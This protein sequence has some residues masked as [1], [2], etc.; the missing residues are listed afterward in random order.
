MRLNFMSFFSFVT[1]GNHEDDDDLREMWKRLKRISFEGFL[2]SSVKSVCYCRRRCRYCRHHFFHHFH[3]SCVLRTCIH[4]FLSNLQVAIINRLRTFRF[5]WLLLTA[6]NLDLLI[7]YE[8]EE[9]AE[10]TSTHTHTFAIQTTFKK[11]DPFT[12]PENSIALL[13]KTIVAFTYRFTSLHRHCLPARL[14]ACLLFILIY[15][16]FQTIYTDVLFL[17]CYSTPSHSPYAL[18]LAAASRQF[19][20]IYRFIAALCAVLCMCLSQ[21]RLFRE[22]YRSI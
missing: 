2:F 6:E 14:P 18:T 19:V 10:T 17:V 12:M 5:V 7:E 16:D 20:S 9:E 8:K 4:F 21:S 22:K 11:M 15:R 1:D 13:P 3:F